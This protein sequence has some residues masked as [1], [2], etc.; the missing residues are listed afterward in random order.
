MLS[1]LINNLQ[2]FDT[3]ISCKR[4]NNNDR[5]KTA[6][7]VDDGAYDRLNGKKETYLWICQF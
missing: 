1:I 6:V 7:L 3:R 5:I 2:N 4:S